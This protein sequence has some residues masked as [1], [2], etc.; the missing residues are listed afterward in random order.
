M[1]LQ[2]PKLQNMGVF[3][4]LRDNSRMLK[5]GGGNVHGNYHVTPKQGS[6]FGGFFGIK[7]QHGTIYS[8]E[9]KWDRVGVPYVETRNNRCCIFF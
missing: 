2:V 4:N 9:V 7:F 5:C 8:E 3:F 6:L 1:F